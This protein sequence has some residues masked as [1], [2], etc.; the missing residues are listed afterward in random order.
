MDFD[1]DVLTFTL[2]THLQ[3]I[4]LFLSNNSANMVLMVGEK[5]RGVIKIL[6]EV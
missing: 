5:I 3:M 4:L 2:K 1:Q 6:A